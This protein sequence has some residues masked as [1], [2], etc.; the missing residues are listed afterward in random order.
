VSAQLDDLRDIA[1]RRIRAFADD[2]ELDGLTVGYSVQIG[3][4]TINVEV[5]ITGRAI[6]GDDTD[7]NE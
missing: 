3:R 4:D 2:L 7:R 1:L 5:R 6:T